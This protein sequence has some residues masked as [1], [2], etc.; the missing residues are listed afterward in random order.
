MAEGN[1]G[2][3]LAVVL[4]FVAGVLMWITVG[5]DYCRGDDVSWPQAVVGLVFVVMG[6][7]AW[8][9]WR[10]LAARPESGKRDSGPVR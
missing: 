3:R 1:A 9:R 5:V 6:I 2:A 10:R 4:W 7:D 8:R